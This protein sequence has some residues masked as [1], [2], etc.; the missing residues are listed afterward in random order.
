MIL[1]LLQLQFQNIKHLGQDD[2]VCGPFEVLT[3]GFEHTGNTAVQTSG[4]QR[5]GHDVNRFSA[6]FASI[7]FASEGYFFHYLNRATIFEP[8]FTLSPGLTHI[9]VSGGR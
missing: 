6:G 5:A 2:E 1:L 9:S 7:A 4:G 8:A 3:N